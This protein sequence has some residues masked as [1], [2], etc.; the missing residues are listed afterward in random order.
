M[1][2]SG[3]APERFHTPSNLKRNLKMLVAVQGAENNFNITELG[4]SQQFGIVGKPD[5]LSI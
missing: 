4:H 2:V 1:E 3:P 5:N